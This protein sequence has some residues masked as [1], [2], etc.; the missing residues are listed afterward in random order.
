MRYAA[1]A[2]AA[3]VAIQ[4]CQSWIGKD[5][6]EDRT[7]M[8]RLGEQ[9]GSEAVPASDGESPPKVAFPTEGASVAEEAEHPL[10]WKFCR[11]CRYRL[12][13]LREDQI[14]PECGVPVA[15]SLREYAY[16]EADVPYLRKLRLGARLA[17]LN[18]LSWPMLAS[19]AAEAAY[20]AFSGSGGSR[21]ALLFTSS[22]VIGVC[23]LQCL[24]A[25]GWWYITSPDNDAARILPIRR[26]RPMVR[27]LRIAAALGFVAIFLCLRFAAQVAMSRT[28]TDAERFILVL[29][30]VAGAS[31]SMIAGAESI[32]VAIHHRNLLPAEPTFINMGLWRGAAALG[33]MAL[34]G[35]FLTPIV[36]FFLPVGVLLFWFGYL[37]VLLA[38]AAELKARLKTLERVVCTSPIR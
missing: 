12:S 15:E 21:G 18:I 3:S 37:A 29:T 8:E 10:E 23:L 19:L 33:S 27:W 13:G 9:D 14:C 1:A 34:I 36:L 26:A 11:G 38:L 22:A 17:L 7:R 6:G 30:T 35:A 24:G 25:I 2:T 28:L 20:R 31:I 4:N 32:R 16:G 5:T